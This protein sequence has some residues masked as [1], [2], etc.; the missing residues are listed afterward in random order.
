MYV[1]MYIHTYLIYI[2][3]YIY[4]IERFIDIDIHVM[5]YSKVANHAAN[6]IS[7]TPSPPTKSFPTKSP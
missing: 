1:Y 2:Y 7:R 3:I 5:M 4:I 6:S